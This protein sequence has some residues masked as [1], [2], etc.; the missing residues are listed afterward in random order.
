[1]QCSVSN[2]QQ[3]SQIFF[4]IPEIHHPKA[5]GERKQKVMDSYVRISRF[6]GYL[7]VQNYRVSSTDFKFKVWSIPTLIAA[8]HAIIVLLLT[9]GWL[10]KHGGSISESG[11]STRILSRL[12]SITIIGT[13]GGIRVFSL[14]YVKETL[15]LFKTVARLKLILCK[16]GCHQKD[17]FHVRLRNF[18]SLLICL[19]ALDE[20]RRQTFVARWASASQYD[21]TSQFGLLA[22]SFMQSIMMWL[23]PSFAISF[24]ALFGINFGHLYDCFCSRWYSELE[25][26]FAAGKCISIK[27]NTQTE[28]Y[29]WQY[30]EL[31]Q[32]IVC[33]RLL[34][35][36]RSVYR[37]ITSFYS[38]CVVNYCLFFLI[39]TL[40]ASTGDGFGAVVGIGYSLLAFFVITAN[41]LLLSYAGNSVRVQVN[42]SVAK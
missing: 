26:L 36:S 2:F 7:P 28:I 4:I 39:Q 6:L 30:S 9:S 31:R 32:I 1:M 16:D 18:F 12:G 3:C 24:V 23:A 37:K 40:S 41:I 11:T 25:K 35:V 21:F 13:A 20:V 8:I 27:E 14:V 17:L 5:T 10:Y 42:K 34:K 38:T 33:Y 22:V 15:S 29:N 19:F